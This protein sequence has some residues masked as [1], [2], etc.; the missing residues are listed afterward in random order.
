MHLE[1]GGYTTRE[2]NIFVVV[3]CEQ[4]LVQL[5][6]VCVYVSRS[7]CSIWSLTVGFPMAARTPSFVLYPLL[8][9][10]RKFKKRGSMF[11]GGGGVGGDEPFGI[12]H[13][14]FYN[15][16]TRTL[17]RGESAGARHPFL[18]NILS[19]TL[20]PIFSNDVLVKMRSVP[21]ILGCLR[22]TLR[23]DNGCLLYACVGA[24]ILL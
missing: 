5:R 18:H 11:A 8:S 2:K 4:H 9:T 6:L 23:A 24:D 16:E 14:P 22:P 10:I 17:S 3:L 13:P 21:T 12:V 20:F 1:G 15:A 19:P 7:V